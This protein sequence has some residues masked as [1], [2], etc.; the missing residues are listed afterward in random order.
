MVWVYRVASAKSKLCLPLDDGL[1]IITIRAV[2]AQT[3]SSG[4]M[5]NGKF[6]KVAELRHRPY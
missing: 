1:N 5:V 6:V 4:C 3:F 2:S